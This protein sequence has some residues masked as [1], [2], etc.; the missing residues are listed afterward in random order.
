MKAQPIDFLFLPI[1]MFS[2]THEPRPI[3]D[4]SRILTFP[5]KLTPGLMCTNLS[6][7]QC[8][9]AYPCDP[10]E[11]NLNVITTFRKKFPN[12]VIGLSDH[13]RN[14]PNRSRQTRIRRK[15]P[16]FQ[17]QPIQS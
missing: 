6:I 5:A 13:Q 8:T 12:T 11:M 2:L 14:P 10:K 17:P 16:C 4:S 15:F 3:Q 7:L 1:L 9:A